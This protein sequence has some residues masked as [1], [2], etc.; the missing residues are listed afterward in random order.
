MSGNSGSPVAN[1][2]VYTLVDERTGHLA[3]KL[4][5]FEDAR[6][7]DHLQ[8]QN[9]YSV[10]W[11]REGS[12]RLRVDLMDVPFTAGSMMCFTPYQP[13][14]LST[15]EAVRGVSIN[16]HSDLYCIHKHQQ[17]VA[18]NGVL[19]NAIYDP[20]VFGVAPTEELGLVALLDD[21]R[22][23]LITADLA[24]T[25]LLVSYLKVFLIRAS[26]MKLAHCPGNVTK[27]EEELPHV[28]EGLKAAIE[29]HY[30]TKHT[31]ADYADLLHISPKALG[32]LVKQHF[33]KTPT[34]LPADA[35]LNE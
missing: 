5:T 14:M 4:F 15:K 19:F 35:T 22:K 32:K 18:C 16:F 1:P 21:M 20:P 11:V 6:Y 31:P 28:V 23:E 10:I 3:F 34:E 2:G 9:Y 33:N 27:P 17:E 13:H 8:R 29:E 12:G 24:R 30:R 7:F 25:E 26:R